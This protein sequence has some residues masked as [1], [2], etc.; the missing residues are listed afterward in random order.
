MVETE[1]DAV[2]DGAAGLDGGAASRLEGVLDLLRA[3]TDALTVLVASGDLAD[4]PAAVLAQVQRDLRVLEHRSAAARLVMLPQLDADGVWAL[5]GSRSF[6][7]WLARHDDVHRGTAN[8]EVRQG[9]ALRDALPA[10]RAAALA[11]AV[12]PDHVS[13]L[14]GAATTDARVRALAAPVTGLPVRYD[15]DGHEV[16]PPSGEE[17]LLAQ[18]ALHPVPGFARLVRRF[19]HVA[20][21]D[22]DD[23]GHRD[24]EDREHFELSLTMGG[25]HVSG[26]L[27]EEHGTALRTALDA[28]MGAPA[29]DDERTTTQRRAQALADLARTCL[30]HGHAGTGAAVR[31]HLNVTVSW[32]ELQRLLAGTHPDGNDTGSDGGSGHGW[33]GDARRPDGDGTALR[34]LTRTPAILEGSTGPLPDSVLRKLACDSEITR[35]VFGPDSQILNV[36]RTQR[37]V[38]GQLRRAV[39]ARDQHCT[40]PGCHEPPQRCEVHHAE[41]HWA[42]DRGETSAANSALLCWHHHTVVDTQ[43]ITMRWHTPG[44]STLADASTA[45]TTTEA[46]PEPTWPE[47]TPS[48][49][50]LG[51][52][53]WQFTDR[54]GRTIEHRPHW[55][56][57]AA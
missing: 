7:A 15:D 43:G 21:P 56:A 12:G 29:A 3:G 55:R 44:T 49:A 51:P 23:R 53:G 39:I 36:G 50:L 57:D 31:P 11:G 46:R 27:T 6:A 37:T 34:N 20:D 10:T 48:E 1:L 9:R 22:A 18:A 40:W 42:R 47:P 45:D 4:V 52:G 28:I 32:D 26:F 24:A 8:R 54:H 2:G 41:R 16:A 38:T 25:W 14:A 33:Q 13:A 19:A 30:D 5:D 17:F 35:I